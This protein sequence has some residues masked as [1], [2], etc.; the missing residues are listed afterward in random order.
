M[1]EARLIIAASARDADLYYASRFHAPDPFPFFQVGRERVIIVSDLELGR[2]RSQAAVE[3]VLPL[4]T[5]EDRAKGRVPQPTML[6]AVEEALRERGIGR[7]LVPGSFPAEYVDKLRDRGFTLRVKE[8]IFFEERLTKSETEV[9]WITEALR[10]AEEAMAIAIQAIREAEIRGHA[11]YRAGAPVT[12]EAVR[13][14]IHHLLLDHDCTA[15][16]TIVAGGEHGSDPH[17]EGTG[18]L[19]AH[20]PIVIDIFPRST[21]THY[22]GDLTRTVLRGRASERVRQMYAAVLQAQEQA[23]SL[24]R[25]GADGA[26]IHQ[27]VTALFEGLGFYTGEANERMQGFFHG[28]GHGLGLEIHEPPR[29]GKRGAI[30]R[31]GNV[32]TVEPGLYYPGDGG[33]RIEDVVV[34]TETGCRNLTT[35]PKVLEV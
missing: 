7:L 5:Y 20:E 26:A 27:E 4:R 17:H 18:P 13:R 8:G 30:L 15:D 28:T 25:D 3:T 33:V 35:F 32:V 31:S 29:I 11:L 12:S 10:V 23:F 16:H 21:R 14:L 9:A 6:D 1:E 24:I 2:A 34:V 19:P 22:F